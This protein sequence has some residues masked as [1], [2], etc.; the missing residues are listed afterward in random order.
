MVT[1]LLRITPIKWI[2][3]GNIFLFIENRIVKEIYKFD[4]ALSI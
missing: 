2:L 1:Y 3:V 4:L